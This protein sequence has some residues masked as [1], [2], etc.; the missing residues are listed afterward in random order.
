VPDPSLPHLPVLLGL[1]L[2][3]KHDR[4]GKTVRKILNLIGICRHPLPPMSREATKKQLAE[5]NRLLAE[6]R[7]AFP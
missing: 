4:E 3:A 6:D 1:G 2:S 5:I 7:K